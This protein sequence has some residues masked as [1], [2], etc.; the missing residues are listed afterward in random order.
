[1]VEANV[2]HG[3]DWLDH[4]DDSV[5]HLDVGMEQGLLV[6]S[7]LEVL[8]GS[9]RDGH[10]ARGQ[11]SCC[12]VCL[13]KAVLHESEV[14]HVRGAGNDGV[15]LLLLA[16]LLWLLGAGAEWRGRTRR[17]VTLRGI[18]RR[19]EGG[20]RGEAGM[21]VETRSLTLLLFMVPDLISNHNMSY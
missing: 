21:N 11:V 19:L 13:G 14:R 4:R 9:V 1:M 10:V 17:G 6:H 12:C 20:G 2:C 16:W 18:G 5:T 15:W 3:Q 8:Q 7:E